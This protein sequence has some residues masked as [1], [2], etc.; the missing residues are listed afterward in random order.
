[1]KTYQ[2]DHCHSKGVFFTILARHV[3]AHL[4]IPRVVALSEA[5][6]VCFIQSDSVLLVMH[7]QFGFEVCATEGSA[8][9]PIIKN[10]RLIVAV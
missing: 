10:D 8:N 5:H 3:L 7:A 9:R 2:N 6:E 4:R 1:M